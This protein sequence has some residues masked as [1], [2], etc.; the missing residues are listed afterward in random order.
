MPSYNAFPKIRPRNSNRIL[1][2]D[3]C[4]ALEEGFGY[5]QLFFPESLKTNVEK[6]VN[7]QKS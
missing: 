5:R 7:S 4:A 2:S 3:P 1:L 6:C